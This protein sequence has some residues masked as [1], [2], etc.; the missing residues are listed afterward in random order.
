MRSQT[1]KGHALAFGRGQFFSVTHLSQDLGLAS[2]FVDRKAGD[3]ENATETEVMSDPKLC[4]QSHKAKTASIAPLAQ[5]F[6]PNL[7]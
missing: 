1:S 2:G 3:A 4:S 7:A 5:Y 6:S